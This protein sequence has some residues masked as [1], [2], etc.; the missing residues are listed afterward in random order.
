[1]LKKRKFISILLTISMMLTLFPFA[2]FAEEVVV[3]GTTE[4]TT[5]QEQPAFKVGEKSYNTLNEAIRNVSAN[6][7][8][9]VTADTTI[10][11]Q[12]CVDNP[13]IL[14]L[15]GHV[16]TNTYKN[17]K[18]ETKDKRFSLIANKNL[19]IKDGSYISNGINLKNEVRGICVK[20]N[21]ILT[22]DNVTVKAEGI[23]VCSYGD[24]STINVQNN[25]SIIG[26]YALNS[27]ANNTTFNLKSS[28][29][30]GSVCG[31]YHNGLYQQF[32][33]EARDTTIV[34]KKDATAVYISGSRDNKELHQVKFDK[35]TIS[36]DTGVETKFANV[37]LN[38]CRVTATHEGAPSYSQNNNGST[39]VGFAVVNTDN[40]VA[41]TSPSPQGTIT[42]TGNEG[43]YKGAVGLTCIIDKDTYPD[44][45]ESNYSISAGKFD[46][47]VRAFLKTDTIQDENGSVV[48]LDE[49]TAVAKIG[50]QLYGYLDVAIEEAVA[51]DKDVT[52][53][54]LKDATIT[55]AQYMITKNITLK[56][57]ENVAAMPK[58]NV[59]VAYG[60][61][62]LAFNVQQNASLTLDGVDMT[63]TGTPGTKNA[64]GKGGL[65]DGTAIN[66]DNTKAGG[67]KGAKLI[68]DNG[69][70]FTATK[71]QRGMI[72][73]APNKP[74]GN[75]KDPILSYSSVDVRNGSKLNVENIDGNASNG[76]TWT[77]DNAVVNVKN[78]GD[79]GLSAQTVTA[80]N[81][82]TITSDN[83][84]LTAIRAKELVV[85]SSDVSV[86]NSGSKLN[87]NA[88]YNHAVE[89]VNDG[90]LVIEDSNVTLQGNKTDKQTI[91]VNDAKTDIRG[92]KIDAELVYA[93][94]EA[95]KNQIYV[96]YLVNGDVYY[97]VTEKKE[98]NDK[99]AY[100]APKAP[101]LSG[102]TF[103][104]WDYGGVTVEEIAGNKV[105]FTPTAGKNVYKFKAEFSYNRP[106]VVEYTVNVSAT[107]NGAVSVSPKRA[108]RGDT[109]TIT[110]TPDK[111][112]VVDAV[113]V[114]DRSGNKVTVSKK[115]DGK[116]TFTMPKSSVT[117]KAIFKEEP[118]EPATMPFIDVAKTAWYYPAVEYV[119]NNDLMNGTT[120]NIF[121]PN[122]SLN[123]AMMAAVLYNMEGGPQC[124]KDGL[125]SDV[126]D[127]KWYTDA[128]NWAASNDIV[129][130]MPDGTYA[131]DQALT[132]EQMASILYRY[133]E[134]KGI[135]ISARADLDK[136]TDGDCVSPWASD[137]VQWAVSEKLING[138]GSEL[139]PKGT[140]S[141]AQVATVLMNFCENVAK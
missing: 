130:G 111:G 65:Y 20:E 99:V 34:G 75:E 13:V 58:I 118:K 131:P 101:S 128:I 108:E 26:T 28:K 38:N 27:F 6:G 8:I 30:E 116:Y 91:F 104:G 36:G 126:K 106:A 135:D 66:L 55:S 14:N 137:V 32:N 100:T 48:N 88:N 96:E 23:N 10:D 15:N 17:E 42:I 138:V 82:A 73:C 71:L 113:V 37:T 84:G 46:Y 92:S 41:N 90:K 120:D 105:S 123:R 98:N 39:A 59:T 103:R 109:V 61:T 72:F 33:L 85:D 95:T 114:T 74:G 119:Y 115:A 52:V 89:I 129:S 122:V 87:D 18:S 139:Q 54:V 132:R 44:F 3:E 110:A 47:D 133:A 53:E 57:G 22:L 35:C 94:T 19:T 97:T 79:H 24:H 5:T 77:V 124:D 60:P 56:K 102:Y 141:R 43:I 40:A 21:V 136:F 127:G 63:I 140:A 76:G 121:A 117:V 45:K 64:E 107:D 68:L 83:A 7:E 80:V 1:M 62:T 93:K 51:S 78:C 125:F 67:Q 49:S 50:N 70:I 2:A 4:T 81:G 112:Y 12:V 86:T 16:I 31:I 69:A 9:S 29:I 134:Y 11:E 25:S